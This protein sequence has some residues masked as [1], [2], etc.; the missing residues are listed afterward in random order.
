MHHVVGKVSKSLVIVLEIIG[1]QFSPSVWVDSA[2]ENVQKGGFTSTTGS[3]DGGDF[4][5]L[6]DATDSLE[7]FL[8]FVGLFA[9]NGS[10]DRVVGD[11]DRVVYILKDNVDTFVE[12]IGH[13]LFGALLRVGKFGLD[14]FKH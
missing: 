4:S 9:R 2:R 12:V 5:G 13:D 6:E 8:L 3:H 7:N 11:F 10:F 14:E 1:I